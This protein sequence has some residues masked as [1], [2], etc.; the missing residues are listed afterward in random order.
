MVYRGCTAG[1][2]AGALAGYVPASWNGANVY[3][4]LRIADVL[5]IAGSGLDDDFYSFA[6]KA[7]FDFVV[8]DADRLPLFAVE[9]DGPQHDSNPANDRTKN[10]VAEKLGLSLARVRQEHQSSRSLMILRREPEGRAV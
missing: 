5:A 9:F 6:L 8:T 2:G 7:H 3:S 1:T 4:K 10:A